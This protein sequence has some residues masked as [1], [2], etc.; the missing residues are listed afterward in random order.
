MANMRTKARVIKSKVKKAVKGLEPINTL[1]TDDSGNTKS[2]WT[3]RKNIPNDDQPGTG[4]GKRG[5]T[6]WETHMNEKQYDPNSSF[7]G[8]QP[9]S[10]G[11]RV[12]PESN[13]SRHDAN[14]ANAARS[15]S[16]HFNVGQ[17]EGK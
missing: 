2:S 16:D 17:S 15:R 9:K 12:A 14:M 10:E 3:L 8:K 7:G 13:L 6:N 11:R 5:V 1:S 4:P